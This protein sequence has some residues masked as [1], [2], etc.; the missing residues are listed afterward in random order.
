MKRVKKASPKAISSF[1]NHKLFQRPKNYFALERWP[2]N[3]LVLSHLKME[4]PRQKPPRIYNNQ[5]RQQHSFIDRP[6][7]MERSKIKFFNTKCESWGKGKWF[8]AAKT[9]GQLDIALECA[10]TGD[11]DPAHFMSF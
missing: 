7:P 3:R 8:A 4:L 11:C 6:T 5:T 1:F 2:H 9:A 10:M